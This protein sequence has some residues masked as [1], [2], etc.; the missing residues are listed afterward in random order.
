MKMVISYLIVHGVCN[1]VWLMLCSSN[2]VCVN[3]VTQRKHVIY[4]II[5]FAGTN[6]DAHIISCFESIA[7]INATHLF[8]FDDSY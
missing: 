2:C 4:A 7:G 1:I 8:T 3:V 6:M 5:W